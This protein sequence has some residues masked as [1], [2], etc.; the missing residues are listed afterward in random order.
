MM[1]SNY[2]NTGFADKA[3]I[4]LSGLC[5]VHCLALPLLVA[6]YPV[7]FVLALSEEFFH[8]AMVMMAIPISTTSLFV[9]CQKHEKRQVLLVGGLGLVLL[10]APF[11]VS[12][13]VTDEQME[14]VVTVLGALLLATAHIMNFRLCRAAECCDSGEQPS[15]G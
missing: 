1:L 3:A 14:V 10:V 5:L 6:F 12:H 11:A 2:I 7:A 4:S 15:L 8:W 9:G 13:E